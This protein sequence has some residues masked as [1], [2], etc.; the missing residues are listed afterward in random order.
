MTPDQRYVLEVQTRAWLSAMRR[1]FISRRGVGEP[2]LPAWEEL[3]AQDRNTLMAAQDA[4]NKAGS[5]ANITRL[6]EATALANPP[7]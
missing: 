2:S 3:T 5:P 6:R 7:D 1:A 4:A